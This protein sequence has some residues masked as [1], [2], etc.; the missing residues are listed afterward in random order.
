MMETSCPLRAT[1]NPLPVILILSMDIRRL[2]H[3]LPPVVCS[4][5]R[6]RVMSW[7]RGIP[8]GTS[9]PGL[10]CLHIGWFFIRSVVNRAAFGSAG[11]DR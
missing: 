11:S 3:V 5:S 4:G 8:V 9:V 1:V 2:V 7:I 6:D 10:F